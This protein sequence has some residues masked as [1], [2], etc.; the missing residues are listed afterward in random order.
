M[1]LHHVT[2]SLLKSSISC[3]LLELLSYRRRTKAAAQ[4]RAQSAAKSRSATPVSAQSFFC[5][6]LAIETE[7]CV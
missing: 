3:L 6:E 2:L 4:G 5:G 7:R 1:Q